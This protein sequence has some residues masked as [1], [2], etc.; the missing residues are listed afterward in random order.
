M[1]VAAMNA[2]RGFTGMPTDG[3]LPDT[4][5]RRF[6]SSLRVVRSAGAMVRHL[7]VGLT[8]V[9]MHCLLFGH[10]DGFAREPHRLFLRCGECGRSTRGWAIASSVPRV[11]AQVPVQNARASVQR[12]LSPRSSPTLR[13]LRKETG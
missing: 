2:W 5:A 8:V 11:A 7:A 3:A 10:D 4:W 9:R 12:D 1:V 13:L 6:A